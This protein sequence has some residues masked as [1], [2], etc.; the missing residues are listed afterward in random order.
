VLQDRDEVSAGRIAHLDE[1]GYITG[2]LFPP[3]RRRQLGYS[4]AEI[5]RNAD[6][7]E[8]RSRLVSQRD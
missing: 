6:A 4:P 5:K 1:Q 7:A 3:E 2:E 8:R